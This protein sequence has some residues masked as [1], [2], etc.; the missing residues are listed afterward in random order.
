MAIET[1]QARL[2]RLDMA[3]RTRSDDDNRV[4]LCRRRRGLTLL[5]RART[6]GGDTLFARQ[7][8][9]G[10]V[11]LIDIEGGT[12]HQWQMP[13]RP[14]R[15]AILLPNGNPGHHGSR[16][17]PY[18]AKAAQRD[19]AVYPCRGTAGR[20]GPAHGRRRSVQE[21]GRWRRQS[22]IVKEVDRAGRTVW[23]W[24]I[25]ARACRTAPAGFNVPAHSD[26]C[27]GLGVV[28]L[29]RGAAHHP[30]VVAR[31]ADASP[32]VMDRLR[33]G[34]RVDADR[35]DAPVLFGHGVAA[36]PADCALADLGPVDLVMVSASGRMPE[37]WMTRHAACL[38]GCAK[39]MRPAPLSPAYARARLSWQRPGCWTGA[40]RRRIGAWPRP[41]GPV[42][43]TC[44]G[45][46]IS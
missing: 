25:R 4:T 16:A 46:P 34:C 26:L 20:A 22:D 27:H 37:D 41:S 36:D 30:D 42:T 39:D 31:G 23:E 44:S 7:T 21:R 29:D 32:V 17:S 12:A 10:I 33:V 6:A 2:A 14:G 24:R 18:R 13:V 19:P 38:H 28:S 9:G 3:P 45:R 8:G 11:D 15:D 43:R 1:F 40:G 35:P 5:E